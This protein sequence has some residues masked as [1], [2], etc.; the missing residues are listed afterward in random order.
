MKAKIVKVNPSDLQSIMF[1]KSKW[2]VDKAKRWLKKNGFLRGEVDPGGEKANYLRFRQFNPESGLRYRSIPLGKGKGIMASVAFTGRAPAAN[3]ATAARRMAP[4]CPHCGGMATPSRKMEYDRESP[5]LR[6][7]MEHVSQ[8]RYDRLSRVN[9]SDDAKWAIGFVDRD[10]RNDRAVVYGADS[11]D[12]YRNFVRSYGRHRVFSI[13]R[14]E[15]HFYG[16]P[17]RGYESG[18]GACQRCGD[19]IEPGMVGVCSQCKEEIEKEKELA[20]LGQGQRF[21]HR[22]YEQPIGDPQLAGRVYQPKTGQPCHCR[23]GIVRDN[24][25]DC[26]GTG[27]RIDFRAIRARR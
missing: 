5:R 16:N 3:P 4:T 12:A 26:E 14:M 24:C 7:R 20:R 2:T 11:N 23:P 19:Y 1:E 6:S 9:P 13:K 27:M 21:R 15:S 18:R 8:G 22:D 10:G 25:P 17:R